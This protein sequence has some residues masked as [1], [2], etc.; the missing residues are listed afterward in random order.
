MKCFL[1]AAAALVLTG[2][3]VAQRSEVVALI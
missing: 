3:A 2:S 1:L